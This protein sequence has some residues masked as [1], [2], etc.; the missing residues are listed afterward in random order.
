MGVC[1]ACYRC[2]CRAQCILVWYERRQT[3]PVCD[4]KMDMEEIEAGLA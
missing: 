2:E 4:R 3:C 1:T